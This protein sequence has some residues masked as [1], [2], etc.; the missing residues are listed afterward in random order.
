[1]DA[2]D[3][4]EIVLDQVPQTNRMVEVFLPSL[5]TS[6]YTDGNEALLADSAAVAS[7]LIPSG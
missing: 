5:D 4:L 2:T 3:A 7:G 1:M 6:I